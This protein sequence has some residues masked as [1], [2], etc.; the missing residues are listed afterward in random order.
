M[1]PVAEKRLKLSNNVLVSPTSSA[2][3]RASTPS[4]PRKHH[5]INRTTT[6]RARACLPFCWTRR[7]AVRL[8]H[9]SACLVLGTCPASAISW[10]TRA[11]WTPSAHLREGKLCS[12]FDSEVLMQYI[13][14]LFKN[15]S[16]TRL[17]KLKEKYGTFSTKLSNTLPW[18]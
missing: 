2:G 16:F 10:C 14:S 18:R 13:T 6:V 4:I 8:R 5:A 11:P 12:Q 7:A 17:N 3:R 9:N 1:P 15:T